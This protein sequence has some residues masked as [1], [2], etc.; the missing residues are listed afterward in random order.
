[1]ER[2]VFI[3]H[4][5]KDKAIAD[6]VV[7]RL[8]ENGIRCWIAPR[9]IGH[10]NWA[11]D[12][13]DALPRCEVFVVII[14]RNAVESKEITKEVTQATNF[15]TYI[16]PFRIDEE[17][18]PKHLQYHLGPCHWL[19]AVT[20]PLEK[21]IDTLIYR[22]K[23][24]SEED[25]VYVN[26]SRLKL[27]EKISSPCGFFTGREQEIEAVAEAFEKDHIVFLQGMGGIGKSEIARGYAQAH[28]GEYDRIIFSNYTSNLI[29]LFSGDDIT[30]ENLSRA[31]GEEGTMWFRRK[32][33]A[34][35]T[36][37]TSRT[38]LIIDNFDTDEDPYMDEVFASSCRI[39]ITTRNDHSDYR[40]I[41]VGP[42][43]DF[44]AVLRIFSD[45]YG[46]PIKPSDQDVVAEMLRL[47][48]CHT[49][50]VELIAKQM[51]ASFLKPEKMLERL[52]STGMN[53]HLKEKV[54]RERSAEK[55]S[56][57]DYIRQLFTFS[58]LGEE[59]RY[60]LSVM[61]LT[62]VSGIQIHMLGEILD[63]DDYDVINDLIGRSW[64]I[65]GDGDSSEDSDDIVRMHPVV[66]L[67]FPDR[68]VPGYDRSTLFRARWIFHSFLSFAPIWRDHAA[69]H[70]T[71]PGI[72]VQEVIF[73]W[74]SGHHTAQ[75]L[76][77]SMAAQL[78]DPREK[79]RTAP[80]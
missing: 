42:I 48:G 12:I 26:R 1:M 17:M 22:I 67:P 8:E 10:T 3:S 6:A 18:L 37:A 60:M 80:L 79:R 56:A 41:H 34:F 64:L 74:Q 5:S 38:L 51:K 15:C 73:F 43:G 58:D 40:T 65:L 50:T 21:H 71:G 63:L 66:R 72:F 47:V 16:L 69:D 7:H 33:E 45:Y 35:R 27:V 4:S 25:A 57:S 36:L 30:I 62:P 55:L 14:S 28:R 54:R 32:L 19:D 46:K 29:D 11:A 68:T 59:Q 2:I 52:R 76:Y 9:D 53:M 31:D 70:C 24:L 61:S 13:M 77:H 23:H 39:L 44:D 49:I 78:P 75:Q 20:P